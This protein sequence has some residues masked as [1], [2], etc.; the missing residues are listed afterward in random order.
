M[1]WIKHFDNSPLY[2]SLLR[3]GLFF[4]RILGYD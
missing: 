4:C 3:R 1:G 2:E